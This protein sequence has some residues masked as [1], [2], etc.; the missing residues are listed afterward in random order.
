M[1][2]INMHHTGWFV[3]LKHC[4][5]EFQNTIFLTEWFTLILIASSSRWW[6]L[7]TNFLFY[8]VTHLLALAVL[9]R[10]LIFSFHRAAVGFSW[11]LFKHFGY[12]CPLFQS[13]ELVCRIIICRSSP[14]LIKFLSGRAYWYS[15][16]WICQ[17]LL[18]KPFLYSK[19]GTKPAASK[20]L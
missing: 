18:L 20:T 1:E 17:I 10:W 3:I 7:W 2:S 14:W 16:G 12:S 9:G 19:N 4:P 15:S 13:N 8:H 6:Q 5:F 11:W